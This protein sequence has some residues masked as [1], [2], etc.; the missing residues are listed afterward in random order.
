MVSSIASPGDW[1][2]SNVVVVVDK[3]CW[4]N[5]VVARNQLTNV[6]MTM[7]IMKMKKMKVK[8]KMMTTRTWTS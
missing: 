5:L 8:K 4:F 2:S 3:C 7:V 6:M 1:R